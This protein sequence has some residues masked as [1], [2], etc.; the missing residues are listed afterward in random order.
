MAGVNQSCVG[1]AVIAIVKVM[2]FLA[3]VLRFVTRYP[4]LAAV[5][6]VPAVVASG[7][8]RD[9]GVRAGNIVIVSGPGRAVGDGFCSGHGGRTC[10]FFQSDTRTTQRGVSYKIPLHPYIPR[11]LGIRRQCK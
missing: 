2:A 7:L 1:N 9:V 3:A 5:T 6:T 8:S 10:T 11:C 4:T